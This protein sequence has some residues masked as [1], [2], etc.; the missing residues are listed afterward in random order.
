MASLGNPRRTSSSRSSSMRRMAS[1]KLAFASSIV[2]PCPFAPDTS[3]Q[4][5]QYPPSG[6]SSIIAVNS[7]FMAQGCGSIPCHVNCPNQVPNKALSGAP[8]QR[9]QCNLHVMGASPAT[10]GLSLIRSLHIDLVSGRMPDPN[11]VYSP[12]FSINPVGNFP[13]NPRFS[14]IPILI[15]LVI[16]ILISH[17]RL[18]NGSKPAPRPT[19]TPLT[20]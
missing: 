3:G 4:I 8:Q 1:P 19:H 10:A 12:G 17:F 11:Y 14:L 9:S 7:P 6:A 15:L 18:K 13:L 16:L 20:T 5:A 2:S